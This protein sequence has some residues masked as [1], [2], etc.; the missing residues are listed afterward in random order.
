MTV[1]RTVRAQAEIDLGAIEH[2]VRTICESVAVPVMTVV[3][4]DGY[5]HGA[6]PVALAALQAGASWLGVAFVDEALELRQS[7]VSGRILAWLLSADD[8]IAEALSLDIDV[9]VA[10]VEMLSQVV[11]VGR[12]LNVTPR[13]HVEV[14]TG[15]ARAGAAE[16]EWS[17]LFAAVQSHVGI[18]DIEFVS[19]WSHLACA[20]EPEHLANTAQKHRFEQAIQTATAAGLRDFFKHIANSA[21]AIAHADLHYDLVRVGI[22]TYGVTPGDELGDATELG[23]RPAM[24]VSAQVAHVRRLNTGD[25]VSYSHRWTASRPTTVGLIPIGY[26][27]GIPRSA[28]NHGWVT[29]QGTE[30]PI[31]GTVCMDQFVVDFG[32]VEV[33]VGARVELFGTGVSS[34]HQWAKACGSI[35]YE[36]V[37]RLG[38]RIERVYLDG[39]Q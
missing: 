23:L 1:V 37:T 12:D 30:Y 8:N 7:G 35:G 22:A 3:K 10:S 13:V 39:H 25:G 5:G 20:D 33:P 19:L 21:G 4:A 26:A 14:D 6:V 31:V 32:D 11:Q 28:T 9:S 2:N 38:S 16:S 34:A 18:G 36:L 15:L 24:T 17:A 29:Y 27:D